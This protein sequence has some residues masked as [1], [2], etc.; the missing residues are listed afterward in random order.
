MRVVVARPQPD[1]ERT[2]RR[3]AAS[4]YQPLV[5]PL[6]TTVPLE[7]DLTV[8]DDVLALTA[9]SA[10]ALL[11]LAGG[12]PASYSRLPFFAVGS[13]TAEA[14]RLSGATDVREGAGTAQE[15]ADLIAAELPPGSGVLRR[16]IAWA[17]VSL[18]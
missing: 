8:A 12:L 4:G 17:S 15:L 16:E 10:N 18:R 9:T 2:G 3:L 6:M 13:R 5:V 1:A 11:V 14:A 7:T